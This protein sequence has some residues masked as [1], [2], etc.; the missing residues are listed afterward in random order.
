[1]RKNIK[2]L[3]YILSIYLATSN[4]MSAYCMDN[5]LTNQ[6]PIHY[7]NVPIA[8]SQL[9]MTKITPIL[10]TKITTGENLIYCSV[11]QAAW[12]RM[13]K[14]VIKSDSAEIQNMPT[15]VKTLNNLINNQPNCPD[16][17]C[18]AMAGTGG[19]G[20]VNK[21]KEAVQKKFGRFSKDF[22]PPKFDLNLTSEEIMIYA[23]FC[24]KLEFDEVFNSIDPFLMKVNNKYMYIDMLGIREFRE[25]NRSKRQVHLLYNSPQTRYS[26]ENPYSKINIDPPYGKIFRIDTKSE[27]D[28]LIISTLPASRTLKQSYVEINKIVRNSNVSDIERLGNDNYLAI[29]KLN[30]SILHTYNEIENKELISNDMKKFL[31]KVPVQGIKLNL[32]ETGSKLMSRPILNVTYACFYIT[33]HFIIY[34]KNKNE[35]LPYFIAYIANDELLKRYVPPEYNEYGTVDVEIAQNPVLHNIINNMVYFHNRLSPYINEKDENGSTALLLAL[36]KKE[37]IRSKQILFFHDQNKDFKIKFSNEEI[38]NWVN[39]YYAKLIFDLVHHGA[40]VNV[41]DNFGNTPLIYAIEAE[42]TSAVK[43]LVDHGTHIITKRKDN[44]DAL[45]IAKERKNSEII[46]IISQKK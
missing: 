31:I 9:K 36:K 5:F 13:Y 20:I 27:S 23:Y 42:D 44:K 16:N 21:I 22:L 7:N 4:S 18:I 24:K 6:N 26:F 10:E 33:D 1:M 15:Y 17:S 41:Y 19:G 34:L 3:L 40:E 46:D 8:S 35:E 12:N 30:L 28:E 38:D 11:F 2:L 32:D 39:H 37:Y 29:T 45:T 43:L 25:N 14:D